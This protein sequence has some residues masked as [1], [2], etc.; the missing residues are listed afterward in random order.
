MYAALDPHGSFIE[1]FGQATGI[2]SLSSAGLKEH[3][4]ATLNLGRRLRLIDLTAPG[5]LARIGADSRLF[6]GERER[7]QLWAKAFYDDPLLALD[8]IL[9]PARHDPARTSAAIFDK[10]AKI[11]AGDCRPW[12]DGGSLRPLLAQ[13]LDYYGFSLIETITAPPSKKGPGRETEMPIQQN[14]FE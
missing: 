1:T 11:E 12:H 13:I 14:L 10:E 5:A 3:G 2:R 9:Y 6:A 4:L 8:G 7:A